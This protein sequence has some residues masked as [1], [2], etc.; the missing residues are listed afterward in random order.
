M[1]GHIPVTRRKE[2]VQFFQAEDGDQSDLYRIPA[3]Q[4]IGHGAAQSA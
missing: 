1:S 3:V 4:H 2:S